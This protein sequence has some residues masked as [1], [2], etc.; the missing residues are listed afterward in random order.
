MCG[1]DILLSEEAPEPDYDYI[2]PVHVVLIPVDDD[3]DDDVASSPYSSR[4]T[5]NSKTSC[6]NPAQRSKQTTTTTNTPTRSPYISTK[7]ISLPPMPTA[8]A[9]PSTKRPGPPAVPPRKQSSASDGPRRRLDRDGYLR[10]VDDDDSMSEP[11]NG[12]GV[13]SSRHRQPAFSR[14]RRAN[15]VDSVLN[16]QPP[17][18]S[19]PSDS[20]SETGLRPSTTTPPRIRNSNRTLMPMKFRGDLGLVPANIAS[21]SVEEVNVYDKNHRN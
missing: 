5:D 15:S 19:S 18:T 7:P 17:L 9:A 1:T 11:L 3:K 12:R 20:E 14:R 2:N 21:L 6:A 4:S 16:W 8:F 13:R 10:S